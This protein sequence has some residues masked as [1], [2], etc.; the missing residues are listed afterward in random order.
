MFLLIKEDLFFLYMSRLN[1]APLTDAFYLGSDQIR[2]TQ[3]EINK[4]RKIIS[5]T[6]I[7][8]VQSSSSSSSS[9]SNKKMDKDTGGGESYSSSD[10]QQSKP[11]EMKRVGYSD[12]VRANF[13]SN[14]SN[15]FETDILKIMQHPKF[16]DIVKN[17]LIIK[18]P[19]WVN[20]KLQNTEYTP[21]EKNR[22]SFTSLIKQGFGISSSPKSS[23]SSPAPGRISSNIKNY[24]IF[25]LVSILLYIF[26]KKLFKN[27]V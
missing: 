7:Q 23:S 10:I 17:Y 20:N 22:S 12:E 6:N 21:N 14:N 19:E 25:F 16:D 3:D 18:H 11:K 2:N 4:L 9:S 26:L 5:D 27:Q 24:I 15:E 8:K 1:F 13:Q